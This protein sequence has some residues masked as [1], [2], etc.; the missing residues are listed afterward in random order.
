MYMIIIIIIIKDT[1][2]LKDRGIG[3]QIG[4][5]ASHIQPAY[6]NH[7]FECPVS[8]D[9]YQR[10]LRLPLYYELAKD[11]IDHIINVLQGACGE[12]IIIGDGV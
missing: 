8:L 5:Y 2:H 6:G 4:T 9:V 12:D 3:T 7:Y 10:A 1:V 11:Q